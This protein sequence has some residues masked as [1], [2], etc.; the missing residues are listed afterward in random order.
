MN[1]RIFVMFKRL[2]TETLQL[3]TTYRSYIYLMLCIS[4]LWIGI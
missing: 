1:T 3:T 4:V 2:E